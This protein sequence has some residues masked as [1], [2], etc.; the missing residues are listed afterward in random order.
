MAETY[1][2]FGNI[3]NLDK[4]AENVVKLLLRDNLHISFA[5][6]CT[7]GMLS[8]LITSVSG[9]SAVYDC[10]VC[11]YSNE[12]KEKLL[13]VD[14]ELLETRGAVSPEAALA[15]AEGAL[16]LSGAD[17]AVSV[18]GIA[19]PTGGTAEKPVGTVYMSVC[20]KDYK[21]TA[22]LRLFE[23]EDKSREN[24][25]KNTA[26]SAFERVEQLLLHKEG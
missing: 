25:R 8:E 13:G 10:G 24:I 12:M 18:T 5:E 20:S 2:P 6:S 15:M 17:I 21:Y 19:G 23:L 7:G 22:L 16:R 14:H 1:F 9:A 3:T 11:T 4:I 26:L